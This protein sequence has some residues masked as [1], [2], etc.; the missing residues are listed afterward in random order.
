[1]AILSGSFVF[2]ISSGLMQTIALMLTSVFVGISITKNHYIFVALE[3]LL[4]L[5]VLSVF[6]S[7]SFGIE[8]FISAVS[9]SAVIVM[10]GC[11]LG[12]SANVK[13]P[14]RK[15]VLIVSAVYLANLL[16]GLWITSEYVSYGD[17]LTQIREMTSQLIEAQYGNSKEL[18]DIAEQSVNEVLTLL[19]KIM[20]AYSVIGAGVFGVIITFIFTKLL[21]K[22]NKNIE[23]V[24][25][26]S[27][28]RG[29]KMMGISFIII[30]ILGCSMQS[31]LMTD[32]FLN[33]IIILTFAFYIFGI[34]YV[35]YRMKLKGKSVVGRA[36][37][38]VFLIPLATILFVFPA[39]VLSMLG[40][41]D[42][43]AD[44]RKKHKKEA[45]DGPQ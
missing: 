36:A 19:Y 12:I 37:F 33:V 29:D 3:S 13:L 42:C 22:V 9:Q 40:F 35:D 34:S 32:A 10:L 38:V 28:L 8:G 14:L 25:S 43:F 5:A 41:V 45:E 24:E 21:P 6:Y 16:M 11:T 2:C 27:Y 20:P 39:L 18:L 31:A 17:L 4:V 7:V 1:M 23:R 15:I 44:F 26:M 30:C